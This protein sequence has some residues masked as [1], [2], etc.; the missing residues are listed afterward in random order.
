VTDPIADLS[1]KLLHFERNQ[2]ELISRV[3][4]LERDRRP[5]VVEPVVVEHPCESCKAERDLFRG[6]LIRWRDG[7]VLGVVP[8]HRETVEALK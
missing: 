4:K 2:N 7:G 3:E 1:A 6:L 5:P 8:L